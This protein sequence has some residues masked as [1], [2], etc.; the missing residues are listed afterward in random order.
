MLKVICEV[1]KG[2]TQMNLTMNISYAKN[3]QAK[4]IHQNANSAYRQVVYGHFFKSPRPFFSCF[5]LNIVGNKTVLKI[6]FVNHTD[7]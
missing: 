4:E 6:L 7:S 2:H 5:K 1:G 3:Y